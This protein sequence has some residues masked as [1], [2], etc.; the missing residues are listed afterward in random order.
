MMVV[1]A[2]LA[3]INDLSFNWFGYIFLFVNNFFTAAQ[4][5]VIKQKLDKKVNPRK[6]SSTMSSRILFNQDFNANSLLFYNSLIVLVP[7]VVLA[8]FTEDW[9]K[10]KGKRNCLS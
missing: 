5:V 7:S 6:F 9:N 1:G 2:V 3:S 8:L 10:V 4:G